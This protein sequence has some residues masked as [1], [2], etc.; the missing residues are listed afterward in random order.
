MILASLNACNLL[1]HGK[2]KVP[3]S[4]HHGDHLV[5]VSHGLSAFHLAIVAGTEAAGSASA[6]ISEI[7]KSFKVKRIWIA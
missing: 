4:C 5:D 7:C 1:W 3:L 6:E 2:G